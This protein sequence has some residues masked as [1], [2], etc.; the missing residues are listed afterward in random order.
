M[1]MVLVGVNVSHSELSKWAM[2][3]F[4]DYN[5]IPMK[6]RP[7]QKAT[8][9]GGDLRQD[10]P[11]PFCHVA[12]GLESC[13]WGQQELAPFALLQTILGGGNATDTSPGA[14]R[15]RLGTGIVKQNPCV[16]SCSAFGTSYSASGLFGVYGVSHADKA[17]EMTTAVLKALAGLGTVSKDELATAKTV[18]KGQL[19]RQVD[20]DSVLMQDLGT[21]LLL[22]GKYGSAADFAKIIDGVTEAQVTTAAKKLLSPKPT[23]AAYGDTHTVPHYSAVEAALKA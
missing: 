10:G 14:A 3:S 13:A 20:D 5:A 1:G 7:E 23:V 8:Y 17:G 18:L 6:N 4:V 19:F 21:Q 22:S 16:E 11:S 2:R 15:G 9:T 12:V